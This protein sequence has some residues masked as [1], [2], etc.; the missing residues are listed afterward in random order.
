VSKVLH[1]VDINEEEIKKAY[2]LVSCYAGCEKNVYDYAS[3]KDEIKS[4]YYLY[5]MFDF[6]IKIE[7]KIDRLK[8]IVN[9]ING[10]G[11]IINTVVALYVI[12]IDIETNK[13]KK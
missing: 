13:N 9:E 3:E 2:L 1:R 11:S 7:A 8:E 10:M 12:P 5:G 6:V 4:I